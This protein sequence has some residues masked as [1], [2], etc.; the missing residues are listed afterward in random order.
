MNICGLT[1]VLIF[2]DF[3]YYFIFSA[4]TDFM[5]CITFFYGYKIAGICGTF[6]M[7][8]VS[9]FF[10]LLSVFHIMQCSGS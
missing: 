7:D 10:G 6:G 8:I 1:S 2:L 3:K 9:W 4:W 5:H